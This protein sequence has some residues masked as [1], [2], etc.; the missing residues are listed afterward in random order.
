[1]HILY[2]SSTAVYGYNRAGETLTEES[3]TAP[4]TPYGESKLMGEHVI[5]AFAS[6]NKRVRYTIFRIGIIYGEG[7]DMGFNRVFR[8]LREGRMK[9]IG[10]G[11]N[12][13]CMINVSDA[14]DAMITV[15]GGRARAATRPTT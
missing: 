10:D 8:M 14:A 1:M 15:L 9:V 5:K 12:H 7:Y 13:L 2:S 4:V 11:S 6:A 3:K